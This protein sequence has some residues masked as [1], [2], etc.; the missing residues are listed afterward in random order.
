MVECFLNIGRKLP[1]HTPRHPRRLSCSTTT[2]LKHKITVSV[3]FRIYWVREN[4]M[5]KRRE[6]IEGTKIKIYFKGIK[7][8]RCVFAALRT[9]KLGLTKYGNQTK[10]LKYSEKKSCISYQF[11]ADVRTYGHRPRFT[12]DNAAAEA[13]LCAQKCQIAADGCCCLNDKGNEI[14]I[15]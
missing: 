12:A 13:V 1:N 9:V 14:S 15:L 2:R 6:V 8:R 5:S 7:C 4:S 11:R 3:L 10:S